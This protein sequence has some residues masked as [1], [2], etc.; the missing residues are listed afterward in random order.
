MTDISRSLAVAHND[1]DPD[2]VSVRPA[3]LL[4]RVRVDRVQ[5]LSYAHDSDAH[6]RSVRRLHD[7]LREAGLRATL[8][9]LHDGQDCK[10]WTRRHRRV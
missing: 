8:D 3:D 2:G 10:G 5:F 4:S 9:Q 6:K 7:L 1:D